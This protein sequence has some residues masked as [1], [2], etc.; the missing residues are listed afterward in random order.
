[1]MLTLLGFGRRPS[2]LIS[3]TTKS[4]PFGILA[5]LMNLVI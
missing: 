4:G 5:E 3:L 2:A 1:M